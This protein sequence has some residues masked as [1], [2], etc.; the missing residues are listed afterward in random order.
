M[1]GEREDGSSL[2]D[3]IEAGASELYEGQQ[4]QTA[5]RNPFSEIHAVDI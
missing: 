5:L 2:F 3:C 4:Y 1:C